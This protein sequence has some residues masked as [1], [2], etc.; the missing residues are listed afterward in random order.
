MKGQICEECRGLLVGWIE[1]SYAV[2]NG[3]EDPDTYAGIKWSR[4][5]LRALDLRFDLDATHPED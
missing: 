1:S 2:L 3:L 5:M 4:A